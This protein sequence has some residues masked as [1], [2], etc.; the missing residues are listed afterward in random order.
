M[1]FLLCAACFFADHECLILVI[2]LSFARNIKVM[3]EG[4]LDAAVVGPGA[5]RRVA[6]LVWHF[7]LWV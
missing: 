4:R 2:I 1:L 7:L 6:N 3:A 5:R